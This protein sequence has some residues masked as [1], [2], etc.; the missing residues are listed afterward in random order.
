MSWKYFK[1][2]K[3]GVRQILRNTGKYLENRGQGNTW[4]NRRQANTFIYLGKYAS[5]TAI[6]QCPPG[7]NTFIEAAA[8]RIT[9]SFLHQ[10][11]FR[12]SENSQ[13]NLDDIFPCPSLNKTLGNMH[14]VLRYKHKKK[15]VLGWDAQIHA[16]Q[17]VNLPLTPENGGGLTP[18][19][20]KDDNQ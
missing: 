16:L 7:R 18:A 15:P 2:G 8:A 4:E 12:F 20:T 6:R 9:L 5:G 13:E 10:L 17:R 14:W 1:I 19:L 11:V 3:I